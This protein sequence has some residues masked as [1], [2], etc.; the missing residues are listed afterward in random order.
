MLHKIQVVIP[1]KTGD[2][3]DDASNSW[4]FEGAAMTEAVGDA[5]LAA[6]TLFYNQLPRGGTHD[7][8]REWNLKAYNWPAAR[9][10]YPVYEAAFNPALAPAATALPPTV[11]CVLSFFNDAVTALPRAR[12]R[13]RIYLPFFSTAAI[14]GTGEVAEGAKN[15]IFAAIDAMRSALPANTF[16]SIWSEA[17]QAQTAVERYRVDSSFD[18]VRRRKQKATQFW[19]KLVTI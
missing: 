14:T 3:A 10:N 12:R 13:G 7:G 8:A 9:P 11:A 5:Y 15:D 17:E 19:E 1:A 18:T 2:P 4:F 16:H 6:L